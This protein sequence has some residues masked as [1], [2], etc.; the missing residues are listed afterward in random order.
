MALWTDEMMADKRDC[1][2][3]VRLVVEMAGY[4]V[5]L[6]VHCSAA[7]LAT[8]RVDTTDRS[9]ADPTVVMMAVCWDQMTAVEKAA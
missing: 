8:Q 5:L 3:A 9:M 4:L 7:Y 1:L 2:S 6:K